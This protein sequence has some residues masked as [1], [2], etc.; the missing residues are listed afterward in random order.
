MRP[1][2]TA[3]GLTSKPPTTV[4]AT[5]LAV[6]TASGVAVAVMVKLPAWTEWPL[7]TKARVVPVTSAS[8]CSRLI[9]TTAT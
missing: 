1:P 8:G 9:P 7:P 5:S 6:A 3:V 2:T 4:I